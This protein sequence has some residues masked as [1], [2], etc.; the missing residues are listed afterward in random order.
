MEIFAL[1][2]KTAVVTGAARGIGK[3]T[4]DLLEKVGIS[5]EVIDLQTLTPF[6]V[7]DR[8]LASVRRTSRLVVVDEDVPG[9]ASAFVLQQLLERQGGFW[10]L[11]QAPVT[12]TGREHRPAYGSDGDYFSKPSREEIFRAVY[13]LAREARPASFPPLLG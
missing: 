10:W 12:V 8:I 2:G 1:R 3:A 5:V 6:D 9:G 7:E 4:A 11:D 13:A